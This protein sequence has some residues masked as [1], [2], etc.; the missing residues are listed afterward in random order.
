MS[1]SFRKSI[2]IGIFTLIVSFAA[3]QIF[4]IYNSARQMLAETRAR[5]DGKNRVNFEKKLLTPHLT[6]QIE[7]LQNTNDVRNFA[8]FKDSFFAATSGGLVQYDDEGNLK[9]HFTVLDGLPESD[10][11]ALFVFADKLFIGTRTKNLVVVR[12]RKV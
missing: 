11:T 5:Q 12:W 10:L 8:E 2:I 7:I 3:Y 1:L 9:K 6:N 4:S